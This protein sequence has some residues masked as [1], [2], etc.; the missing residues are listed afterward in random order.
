MSWDIPKCGDWAKSLQD[1]PDGLYEGL[2]GIVR[3]HRTLDW[4][5]SPIPKNTFNEF[6]YPV[7]DTEHGTVTWARL[8]REGGKFFSPILFEP[9]SLFDIQIGYHAELLANHY[10]TSEIY[11]KIR[12]VWE[13]EEIVKKLIAGVINKGII[14][15]RKYELVCPNIDAASMYPDVPIID[16]KETHQFV[17]DQW[18]K[19]DEDS[20]FRLFSVNPAYGKSPV[21]INPFIDFRDIPNIDKQEENAFM[22]KKFNVTLPKT[23]ENCFFVPKPKKI[24]YNNPCTIVLWEDG[25][26]TIC[27]VQEGQEFSEYYGYL[28]CLA[29]KIYGTNGGVDRRIKSVREYGKEKKEKPEVTTDGAIVADMTDPVNSVGPDIK[30]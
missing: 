22:C 17:E 28:A 12:E 25:T 16:W 23:Y 30:E 8:I 18:R 13:N 20:L 7:Y 9:Q 11:S 1:T 2:I 5:A 15:R 29:K 10:R 21:K 26:K 4:T 14:N 27:R 6:L 3:V 19:Y 24:I